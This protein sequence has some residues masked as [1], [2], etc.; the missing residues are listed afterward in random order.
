MT[1]RWALAV[2]SL[3]HC[4]NGD[5]LFWVI[6]TQPRPP[7]WSAEVIQRKAQ[8]VEQVANAYGM[9]R[10]FKLGFPAAGLD[11][12]VQNDLIQS[13]REVVADVRPQ[14]VYLVH[15]GDV[16]SDHRSLFAAAMSVLKPFHMAELGVRRVLCFETLSSTDSA[17]TQ[18]GT[19]FRAQVFH[20]IT[21]FINR[22]LEIMELFETEGQPDPMP[23]RP[24]AIR[25]LA[26]CRGATVGVEYAEAFE[27]VR[28]LV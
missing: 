10:Y 27:L 28:E 14:V 6:A 1:R 20:D 15:G 16:H 12:V 13:L 26:R 18:L 17:P 21:R 24:L 25:A 9:T 22:K 5:S 8:E 7:Q 3:R 11:A 23:R 2:R 19:R 4:E